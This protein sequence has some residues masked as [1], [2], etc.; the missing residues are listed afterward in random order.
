MRLFYAALSL[1]FAL[2]LAA[3]DVAPPTVLVEEVPGDAGV[4]RSSGTFDLATA[5]DGKTLYLL[6][7]HDSTLHA[8]RESG[9]AWGDPVPLRTLTNSRF[10]TGGGQ[11]EISHGH[12][13]Y[14]SPR[15]VTLF[16]RDGSFVAEKKIFLPGDVEAVDG[17]LWAVSL[18][19]MP[20]PADP[21]KMIGREGGLHEA[22]R[23]IYLDRD[24][25][26]VSDALPLEEDELSPSERAGKA[27]RLAFSGDQ[28]LATEIANYKVYLLK[29]SG[30]LLGE[31]VE[32]EIRYEEVEDEAAAAQARFEEKIEARRKREGKELSPRAEKRGAPRAVAFHHTTVVRSTAWDSSSG[33]L[34][35]L[36]AEDVVGDLPALD[37]LDLATGKVERVYLEAPGRPGARFVD[38]AVGDE[39][40]Y[41]RSPKGDTPTYRL[42]RA[43]LSA[44]HERTLSEQERHARS[45]AE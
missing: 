28:L 45:D 13:V 43:A 27:L 39:Y 42:D 17:G 18:T 30:A 31:L 1:V 29:R 9:R 14:L 2:P 36:L 24:L 34:L 19:P 26:E 21:G 44:A 3:E 8:F 23:I 12:V 7:S 16:R 33:K 37:A 32:P 4:L 38:L 25:D 41:L 20:H 40:I 5:P 22:P 10:E 35:L 6:D 11:L 15:G